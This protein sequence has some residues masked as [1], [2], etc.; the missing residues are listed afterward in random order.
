MAS[1]SP[2]AL[3]RLIAAALTLVFVVVAGVVKL[4]GSFPGDRWA[5]MELHDAI[6]TRLDDPMVVVG[7]VTDTLPL[8]VVSVVAIALLMGAGRRR[9]ALLVLL[10]VG[11]VWALNPLLKEIVARGRP[12]VRPSPESTSKFGFPSG[13]AAHTAGL[14]GAVV[15]VA[16]TR[17]SRVRAASLGGALVVVVGFSRLAIGVHHPTDVLAGWLWVG[18]WIA[19]LWSARIRRSP[20]DHAPEPRV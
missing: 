19:F 11:V 5:L 1:R 7:D 14:L 10:V 2:G 18:A 12:D 3:P 8:I 20:R 15:L 13:H 17:P 4:D 6:G 16:R 9:D